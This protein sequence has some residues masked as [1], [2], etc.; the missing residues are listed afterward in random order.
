MRV[1]LLQL[2]SYPAYEPKIAFCP[3][4]VIQDALEVGDLC[5]ITQFALLCLAT[6]IAPVEG[7]DGIAAALLG[8]EVT[9]LHGFQQALFLSV[10]LQ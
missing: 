7:L 6:I 8:H 10:L 5:P 9:I 3:P 2:L 4:L 1:L